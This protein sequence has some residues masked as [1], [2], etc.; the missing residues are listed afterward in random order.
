MLI[1]FI[2]G[3]LLQRYF[4]IAYLPEYQEQSLFD[5]LKSLNNQSILNFSM[6]SSIIITRL[7]DSKY[8]YVYIVMTMLGIGSKF[9]DDRFSRTTIRK[10][11][12]LVWYGTLGLIVSC[13]CSL[14]TNYSII[15]ANLFSVIIIFCVI[16]SLYD[17][18]FDK[19]RLIQ[20]IC[21]ICLLFYAN[22][23]YSQNYLQLASSFNNILSISW[24]Y[25]I[26]VIAIGFTLVIN[27]ENKYNRYIGMGIL[28]S[29]VYLSF[30]ALNKLNFVFNDL[31]IFHL[32][33]TV[34]FS[35]VNNDKEREMFYL[36][37]GYGISFVLTACIALQLLPAILFIV[38]IL[39][40]CIVNKFGFYYGNGK[41]HILTMLG[42]IHWIFIELI[43]YSLG[44]LNI[45]F[46]IVI[47][48]TV[49]LWTLFGIGLSWTKVNDKY[50][51]IS[52]NQR[53]S[54]NV[55]ALLSF[56]PYAI[57]CFVLFTS[58][59]LLHIENKTLKDEVDGQ[60]KTTLVLN[61][62]EKVATVENDVANKIVSYSYRWD[63]G[64]IVKKDVAEGISD[65]DI[66][67]QGRILKVEIT[68]SNNKNY[69][70][71]YYQN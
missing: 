22:I 29:L 43:L 71:Y 33:A 47:I 60:E 59:N 14:Y 35:V 26:G 27:Q 64:P 12:C 40:V 55:M 53:L 17:K 44:K 45:D 49:V 34:F 30:I 20:C 9:F 10:L 46:Y 70:K 42:A 28:T 24:F 36:F 66:P 63:F 13:F 67:I 23:V 52:I 7:F 38:P 39:V 18:K 15:V 4:N 3:W 68:D 21:F 58:I 25:L 8:S 50:G 6:E 37:L 31:I 1:L 62:S 48:I 2:I 61:V 32:F 56:L 69:V 41:S 54:Q 16:S 51:S 57:V 5:V 65:F 19:N 11:K